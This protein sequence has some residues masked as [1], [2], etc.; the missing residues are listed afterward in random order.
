[1]I[2]KYNL[3]TFLLR[4]ALES[5]KLQKLKMASSWKKNFQ[6]CLTTAV[7]EVH[8]QSINSVCLIIM[9]S[10][11][12]QAITKQVPFT[13]VD[14]NNPIAED[15]GFWKEEEV[16]KLSLTTPNVQVLYMNNQLSVQ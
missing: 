7:V 2:K 1:M 4:N 15:E 13:A 9:L 5:N 16:L 8:E 10:L 3:H 12:N 6:K 11:P 14:K